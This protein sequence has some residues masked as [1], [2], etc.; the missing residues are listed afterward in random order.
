MSVVPELLERAADD[1]AG[2]RKARGA[3]FTPPTITR[4]LAQWAIRERTDAV[5][6]PSAGDAAFLVEAVRRLRDLGA[7]EPPAV[8]GIEIHPHSAEVGR[9][10]IQ[11]IGGAPALIVDDFFNVE[12]TARF[13]A[14]IGN[15]PYIR[16]QQFTGEARARAREAAFRAGVALTGLASSWAAFTVQSALHLRPGGR[17]GLVLPAELLS[18]NYAAPVRRFLFER[19]ARLELVLFT[20]QVFPEAEADVVLLMASGFDEGASRHATVYETTNAAGLT[21]LPEGLTFT[22][23]DP[24]DKW[25]SALVDPDAIEPLHSLRQA[26]AFVPLKAWGETTLGIVTGNN[27]YFTLSPERAAKLK[28][29]PSELVPLSPPGS[30]HLRGLALTPVQLAEL[31][32]AGRAT[33]MFRPA[34]DTLSPAAKRYVRSGERDRV[35]EAYKCRTRSPWYR[36]PLVPPADLLLTCMNADTPRLT[37]NEAGVHHLNSVHGV[38]LD[39]ALRELGRDLLPLASLNSVT[40]LNAEMV[41]RAYGGGILKI[42]PREADRWAV[43]SSALITERAAELRA[44]RDLVAADLAGGRLW[45]AV[46]R[47]DAALFAGRDLP[48]DADLH[49]VRAAHTRLMERRIARSRTAR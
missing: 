15:P 29:D 31:G 44:V 17:L 33:L 30:S 38:Y 27:G 28:L 43:P 19:F 7:A 12:P 1:S 49:A 37:T 34:G 23:T 32:D 41:G 22:P 5:L 25:N 21:S 10:R 35:H 26:G 36:V 47:V 46:Q 9:E 11:R 2:A 18:V 48:S 6:E 13:D 8:S 40:V 20:E 3:F 45:D 14:V 16:Y 24:S 39:A 42:E 4:F